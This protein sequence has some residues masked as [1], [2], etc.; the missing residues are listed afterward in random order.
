MLSC[1]RQRLLSPTP[2]PKVERRLR[3]LAARTA[4]DREA[5]HV[6]AEQRT[7][8]AQVQAQ[9]K[10]VS[11]NLA[12]AQ[13]PAQ[14]EAISGMFHQMKAQEA[15][16]QARIAET[17]LKTQ[18]IVDADSKVAA[19]MG[20][21]H[22]LTDLVAH[23]ARLDLAAEVFRLTN[24]RHFL[25]FQPVQVKKRVLNKIAGG[26]VTFGDVPAPL[27]IYQGPT[28]RQALNDDREKAVVAAETDR[29]CLP[30]PE[31]SICSPFGG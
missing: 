19:A 27:D 8:L 10:T 25:K 3:E 5:D 29:L 30:P 16:L 21:M 1:H 15:A 6:L 2:L 12:L 4:D 18:P 7:E 22:R 23:S 14:F 20:V 9:L 11:G 28:G 31:N 13:T 24:A 26:F 17:E